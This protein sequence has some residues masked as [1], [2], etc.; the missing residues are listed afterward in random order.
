M[1]ALTVIH[2]R[3]CLNGA[4]IRPAGPIA[5]RM[6]ANVV[7]GIGGMYDAMGQLLSGQCY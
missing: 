7:D 6:A 1:G 5:T 3:L 2:R 4:T